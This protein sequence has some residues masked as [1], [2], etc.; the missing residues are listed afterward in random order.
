[1]N[2]EILAHYLSSKI[3]FDQKKKKIVNAN[4]QKYYSK[5]I[6]LNLTLNRLRKNRDPFEESLVE[7]K[8]WIEQKRTWTKETGFNSRESRIDLISDQ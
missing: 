6:F 4:D 3:D 5:I 8:S 1:M 2:F 7:R